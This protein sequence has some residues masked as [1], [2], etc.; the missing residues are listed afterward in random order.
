[1]TPFSEQLKKIRKGKKMTQAKLA[2]EVGLKQSAIANYEKGLRFPDE[3]TLIRFAQV[4]STSLDTLLGTGI[5]Y[6]GKLGDEQVIASGE[7]FYN[8]LYQGDVKRANSIIYNNLL[9]GASPYQIYRFIILSALY[10]TGQDWEKGKLKVAQEH[11]I[12][13]QII[14][15]LGVISEKLPHKPANGKK[16]IALLPPGE[17]HLIPLRIF[18]D[19]LEQEGLQTFFLGRKLP[20]EET[21]VWIK[22]IQPD[23]VIL[24]LSLIQHLPSFQEFLELITEHCPDI[25]LIFAGGSGINQLTTEQKNKMPSVHFESD[26]FK[27]VQTLLSLM[28]LPGEEKTE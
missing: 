6:Y 1:M 13:E 27:G 26:L 15:I 4:L 22:D 9:Y 12:S 3:A 14:K 28:G 17:E 11:F 2:K 5:G 21:C 7:N 16:V 25:P 19:L 20:G 18:C 24:S 8:A 10:K 23:A